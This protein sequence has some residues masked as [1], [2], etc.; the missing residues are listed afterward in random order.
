MK[1]D[2]HDRL[3]VL[4]KFSALFLGSIIAAVGL[5]LFLVPNK[6][7]DGGIV[8]ISIIA[9]YLSVIPLGIFTFI[10]NIPFLIV[11]YKQIGKTFVIS[12]LFSITVFSI[13]VSLLHP[14]PG[15]IDDILL[16][17][18]F[19]GIILGAGI[20]LILRNGGSLDGTEIVAII[21]NRRSSLS[22]GQI[23]MIMNIFIFIIAALVLGWNRA[24]YSML[25]Y[26]VAH[27]AIDVVIEGFDE[28]KA[29]M[30]VTDHEKEI[31]EA[32]S[33]RLGR[34]VTFLDGRGG[35]SNDK[36]TII[37]SVVTRLEISKIRSIIYEKDPN[38]FVTIN[39]VSEV[40]GGQYKKR[41]IH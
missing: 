17:T 32:I 33:A 3:K 9:S 30:I 6:I 13:S 8:G 20:G 12:S 34:G 24:L 37:Y 18:I 22:V 1:K 39:D 31:G 5:E 25:A 16:A 23:V 14:I 15:L 21:L 4:Y 19:G 29:V 2:R 35:F 27:K 28:A 38:A 36:K 40:M 41:A 11:G 10:L 7:I 26:F